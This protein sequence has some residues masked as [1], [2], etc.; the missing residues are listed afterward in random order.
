VPDIGGT[1]FILV[2][3]AVGTT[4]DKVNTQKGT[5]ARVVLRGGERT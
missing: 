5:T 3:S 2:N 1:F 4:F